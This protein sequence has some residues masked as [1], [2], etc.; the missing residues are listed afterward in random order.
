VNRINVSIVAFNW[1]L[2]NHLHHIIPP[3]QEVSIVAA[4]AT[5]HILIFRWIVNRMPVIREDTSYHE[6]H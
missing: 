5:M 3:W 2:P 4:V 1:N 6:L